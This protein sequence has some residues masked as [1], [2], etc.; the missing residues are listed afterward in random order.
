MGQQQ[1]LLIILGVIV[2]GIAIAVGITMF[3]A[4]SISS[5]KDGIINDL[6]NLAANAYQYKI[7][8]GTMGGGNSTYTNYTIPLKLRTNS[9]AAYTTTNVAAKSI[10]FKGTSAQISANTVTAVLDS[11]GVLT[12]FTY[13][14]DFQ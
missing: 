13:A 9:N 7:R 12:S 2:V 1:L 10:T 14:G 8:P 11:T 5:N 4:M 3:G 6:N